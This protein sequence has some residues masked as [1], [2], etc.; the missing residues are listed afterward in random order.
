MTLIG[1]S[2]QGFNCKN[3]YNNN[4]N[5]QT[6]YFQSNFYHICISGPKHK[7]LS[8][9]RVRILKT[10]QINW[11][12]LQF[13]QENDFKD[14]PLADRHKLKASLVSNNFI[15]PFYVWESDEGIT[16]CLDGKH[17]TMLLEELINEGVTVP[18]LL[19]ATFVEC[20]DKKEAAKLVLIYSSVYAKVTPVGFTDFV[21]FYGLDIDELK[22]TIDLPGISTV[23]EDMP[24]A[25][26]PFSDGGVQSKSQFGV[27]V[28]C[29]DE[30]IQEGTYYALTEQ[31][32]N[33][34]IVVT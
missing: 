33:C 34:K 17:R 23:I 31:G 10:E 30:Q 3:P 2:A 4:D 5:R 1:K 9:V 20:I 29:A 16:Y 18:L 6:F 13:I 8:A 28:F 22:Q 19:P 32:Y 15:E 24:P 26:D 21:E 12:E 27:I 25:T 14:L 11:R 7:K